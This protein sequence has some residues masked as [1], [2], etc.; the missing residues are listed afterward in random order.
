MRMEEGSFPSAGGEAQIHTVTW[1]PEGEPAAVLQIVHGMQEY[2]A[3]YADMAK[4]FCQKGYAVCGADHLGHGKSLIGGQLGYFGETD[5]S[6]T[7]VRDVEQFH[8]ITRR[9]FPGVPYFLFGH[10]MGSFIT[11]LW[12]TQ[13]A[14]DVSG[15]ILSGTAGPTPMARWGKPLLRR[16]WKKNGG[17][18]KDDALAG[19]IPTTYNRRFAAE[20]REYAWLSSDGAVSERFLADPL[21]QFSFTVSALWTLLD[22]LDQISRRSWPKKVPASLPILLTA[23]AEDPVGAHGEGVRILYDRMM[24]RGFDDLDLSLYPDCRHELHNETCREQVLCDWFA[25]LE[26]HR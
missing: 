25:W 14:G 1:L 11:R 7:L 16:M 5:T 2:A 6:Q 23:G 15:V 26:A 24:Q 21:T 19:R 22:L 13:Y 10:S 8:R 3:R 17:T 9:R 4:W 12:M 18:W 20:G